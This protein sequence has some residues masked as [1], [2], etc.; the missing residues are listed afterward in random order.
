MLKVVTFKWTKPG[1]RSTFGAE[2]VNTLARM[3]ARHYPDPH[4]VVC[5]TD[6]PDGIDSAVEVIPLW[7]DAAR[8]KNPSWPSGP[9]CFRRLKVFSKWF[10]DTIVDRFVVLDL[11]VVITGDL[12]P[13][14]N[15][16]EGFVI[17][18]PNH[19]GVPMCGSMFMVRPGTHQHIWDTFDASLSPQLATREGYKG[20]D[21]AW[22]SY[23][24]RGE[25]AHWTSRDGVYGYRDDINKVM[26]R[27]NVS[28]I[29]VPERLR[30]NLPPPAPDIKR[31]ELPK[32]ARIV[33]FPGKPD[34]WDPEAIKAS[35]WIEEHYR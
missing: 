3:V 8:L 1:Y 32:D 2:H 14:W 15:R 7:G 10:A 30:K 20:S 23:C 34:P 27:K 31:G 21:Q 6:D 29:L 24:L 18:K 33:I 17:W 9:S 19:R 35:P 12:R 4:Q 11:D 26:P 25:S 28:R 5:V 22:I 13:L 16:S